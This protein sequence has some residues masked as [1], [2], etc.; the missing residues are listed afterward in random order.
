LANRSPLAEQ[1]SSS[2]VFCAELDETVRSVLRVGVFGRRWRV[3]WMWEME[4]VLDVEDVC[5]A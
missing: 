5:V 4:C 2:T 3:C 1:Y